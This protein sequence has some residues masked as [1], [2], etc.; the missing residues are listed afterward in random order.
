MFSGSKR[1]VLCFSHNLVAR[2]DLSLRGEVKVLGYWCAERKYG[3]NLAEAAEQAIRLGGRKKFNLIVVADDFWQGLVSLD[4]DLVRSLDAEELEQA[5]SFEA[6]NYSSHAA[7]DSAVGV[8]KV[9]VNSIEDPVWWVTQVEQG[10][11]DSLQLVAAKH[12]TQLLE[13][14]PLGSEPTAINFQEEPD[15]VTDEAAEESAVNLD[16]EGSARA[17]VIERISQSDCLP[18]ILISNP[19][20]IE[21]NSKRMSIAAALVMLAI[22]FSIDVKMR[23]F[24]ASMQ[25]DLAA[26]DIEIKNEKKLS[27][28]VTS[29]S[30]EKQKL[31]KQQDE[32]QRTRQALLVAR[33]KTAS[34]EEAARGRLLTLLDA[35]Q[36]SAADSHWISNIEVDQD[37]A[38]VSGLAVSSESVMRFNSQLVQTLSGSHWSVLPAEITTGRDARFVSFRIK[39]RFAFSESSRSDANEISLR[40]TRHKFPLLVAGRSR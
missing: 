39:L 17:L 2:V 15:S 4:P 24:A 7:L 22:C 30:A 21:L 40:S 31:A 34:A 5:L 18:R 3:S 10:D 1:T 36:V 26:I 37:L 27:L 38:V 33:M 11:L 16:D 19:R 28:R 14:W 23:S 9:G 12:R 32:E 8:L 6:E 13:C 29:L 35:F 20:W 25:A